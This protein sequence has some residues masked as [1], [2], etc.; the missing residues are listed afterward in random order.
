[1]FSLPAWTTF[2]LVSDQF[3]AAILLDPPWLPTH[4][5]ATK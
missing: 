3:G 4:Q 5:H 2:A 1:M